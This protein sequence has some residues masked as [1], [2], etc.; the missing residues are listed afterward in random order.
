MVTPVLIRSCFLLWWH[1]TYYHISRYYSIHIWAYYI[2]LCKMCIMYTSIT[3]VQSYTWKYHEILSSVLLRV[4]GTSNN[5]N[6][7]KWVIFF[8]YMCSVENNLYKPLILL[9]VQM[10]CVWFI[11]PDKNSHVTCST[12]KNSR[13]TC[14]TD[15]NSRMTFRSIWWVRGGLTW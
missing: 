4:H 3:I 5:A 14:S 2:I 7:N 11:G 8:Q 9:H 6:G 10:E 1:N 12:D 13:V 15:A